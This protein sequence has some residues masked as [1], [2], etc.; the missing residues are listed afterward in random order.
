MRHGPSGSASSRRGGTDRGYSLGLVAEDLFKLEPQPDPMIGR[1]LDGRYEVLGRLGA[2]GMGVVYKGRQAKLGRHVAIKVLHRDAAAI[3]EWRRRFEREARALSELAHPNVVPVTDSGID[4]GM[5]YLVMELLQGKSLADLIK[6]GP[7]P[8]WRAL[9]IARQILR[10]LAFAHGKG[11]VHRDLK[12]AN[13]F[14]QEL[15]DQADH[16]RL[17]DFGTAKFLEGSSSGT[18]AGEHL[19]RVGVVFGTPAYMS[20]EQAKAAAVDAR[21]DVYSAGVLLFELL[22][23]RRPF[24]ADSQEGY[25]GA[26]LTQPVPSLGKVRPNL[27]AAVAF[28]QVV[29]KAMA[30]KP[31]A[32]FKDA[33]ALLTALEAVVSKLP[34]SA[35]TPSKAE[36]RK[37][38]PTPRLPR[39]VAA[40][41]SGSRFLRRAIFMVTAA[42]AGVAVVATYLRSGGDRP[43]E[44]AAVPAEPAPAS[45]K[46]QHAPAPPKPAPPPP[47]APVA[48]QPTE[49]PPAPA[50]P[51]PATTA[52]LPTEPPAKVEPP[53]PPEEKPKAAEKAEK[54]A[55]APETDA[56]NPWKEPVPR[57]IKPLRDRI[58]R[59]A[60]M[61]QKAL[62]PLYTYARDNPGDPRPWL[63]L[64]RAYAQVDWLSDSVER[65][66]RAHK[67]DPSS[68][69]DPQM[70][71]DLL[72]GAAHP[73]A[74]RAAAR[75]I[76]DIY[77][78]EAIPALE[79]AMEKRAAEKEPAARLA[80]LRESLPR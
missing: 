9:D 57:A 43:G 28:Q 66:V 21:T 17:L 79:K 13:V 71:A 2:G 29:E 49:P 3:P 38:K 40:G 33:E 53:P 68:R 46:A 27:V 22:A 31:A 11:I 30:K 41:K 69:G 20:P 10:G 15:P 76:R 54:E 19:T 32:R 52:A 61:S 7:L 65:Y 58:A 44:T 12:P 73:T 23:G 75:A 74:N 47:P 50:Q 34:A 35:V 16:V 25:M 42:G 67:E 24:V 62:A 26:H 36:A 64:G 14:L 1:T 55:A 4:R 60:K 18:M 5:P 78:A 51:P 72:K 80:R 70:L 59:N 37:S 48:A 8:L 45:K 39:S 63:L 6:E 77:G 56:R